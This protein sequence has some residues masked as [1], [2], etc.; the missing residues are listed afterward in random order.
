MTL[1]EHVIAF[2]EH[3]EA[4]SYSPRSQQPAGCAAFEA[5]VSQSTPLPLAQRMASH[6]G[7]PPLLR[8]FLIPLP[9]IHDQFACFF[10]VSVVF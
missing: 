3:L 2:T 8:G 9:D 5:P 6:T 4:K 1:Q 7:N 10:P